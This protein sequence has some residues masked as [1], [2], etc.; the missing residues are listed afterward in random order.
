MTYLNF[1]LKLTPSSAH[2]SSHDATLISM[3]LTHGNSDRPICIGSCADFAVSPGK[4]NATANPKYLV[5]M[6]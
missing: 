4:A 6:L 3:S 1:R 2:S 5:T